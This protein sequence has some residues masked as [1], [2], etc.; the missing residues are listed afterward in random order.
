MLYGPRVQWLKQS[1]QQQEKID[2]CGKFACVLCLFI[3]RHFTHIELFLL[4]L[5]LNLFLMWVSIVAS[6]LKLNT[7]SA[8]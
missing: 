4:F 6:V 2:V 5:F 8:S 7:Y 1:G 3:I